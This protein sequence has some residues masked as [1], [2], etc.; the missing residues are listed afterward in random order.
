MFGIIIFSSCGTSHKATKD[1]ANVRWPDF[2][3]DWAADYEIKDSRRLA[4]IDQID[5]VYYLIEDSTSDKTRLCNKLCQLQNT[6]GDAIMH[7]TLA[8]FSLMMRATAR[9][10]YGVLYNNTWLYDLDCSCN[11]LDYLLLDSKWYTSSDEKRDLMYTSIIGQS[12]QAPY[13]SVD[14]ILLA[15]DSNFGA[16]IEMILYNYIDTVMNDLQIILTDSL[17]NAIDTLSKSKGGFIYE[18]PEESPDGTKKIFL[19]LEIIKWLAQNGTITIYYETPH[20][21]V[22]MVG[23]PQIS[24]MEQLYECPRLKKILDYSINRMTGSINYREYWKSY[25]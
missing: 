17:G 2:L 3:R 12:W 1:N 16:Q 14:L 21:T 25:R 10:F 22:E 7:D 19:P 8:E 23:Y 18:V 15:D 20:D 13:R 6:I 24:F 4:I 11:V 5:K 9:N